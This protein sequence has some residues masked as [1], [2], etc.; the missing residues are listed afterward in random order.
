[1]RS[2]RHS[3]ALIS[4]A[5]LTT[6]LGACRGVERKTPDTDEL[7]A[8]RE[9]ARERYHAVTRERFTAVFERTHAELLEYRAGQRT[10]PPVIDFLAISGGGDWGS[11]GVG[12]M[13]GW[14]KIDPAHPLAW[15]EFDAVTGVSTGALIAPFAFLGDDQAMGAVERLYRNPR[16]DWVVDRG[17]FFFLPFNLSFKVVPGLERDLRAHMDLAMARRIADEGGR[18]RIL[19][20]NTTDLDSATPRVFSLVLESQRAVRDNDMSRLHD[21]VLA[22]AGIP[23]AFPYREIDGTMY[24]DGG[25]TANLIYGGRLRENESIPAIWKAMYPNEPVPKVRYWVIFNNKLRTLPCVVS[26][27]WPAIVTRSIETSIRSSTIT[28]IRHLMAMAE[29]FRLKYN[30]EVEVRVAAVPDEW[31]PAEEGDFSKRVMNDLADLGEQ[32]GRD[33]SIWITDV[34]DY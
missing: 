2:S 25:V 9:A 24:V 32:M 18:G 27:R 21:I 1:M 13:Q 5:V 34:D 6:L 19:A 26:A 33:P 29:V 23:G 15:P 12:F 31:T 28:S 16:H 10:Q 11:F 30:V 7:I 8:R 20:V 17:M 14:R 22:S 3:F 4:L